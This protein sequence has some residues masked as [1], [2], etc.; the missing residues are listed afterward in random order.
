MISDEFES[1]DALDLRTCNPPLAVRSMPSP[2]IYDDSEYLFHHINSFINSSCSQTK[3]SSNLQSLNPWEIYKQYYYYLL[4]Q[5]SLASRAVATAAMAES[6]TKFL[7]PSM[8]GPMSPSHSLGGSD[9]HEPS[10]KYPS[11]STFGSCNGKAELRSAD[12]TIGVDVNGER[13][14]ISRPLT[15]RHVRHGTGASPQTLLTLRNMIQERQ[16]MKE[17]GFN[18]SQGKHKSNRKSQKRK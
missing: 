12:T 18:M 15:G 6:Y 13:K 17:M 5:P 3:D 4:N 14:R 16:K 8:M 2:T 7:N 10:L 11:S 9:F 1:D